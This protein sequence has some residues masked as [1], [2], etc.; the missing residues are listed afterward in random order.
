LLRSAP[1]LAEDAADP[2]VEV[3]LKQEGGVFRY[4]YTNLKRQASAEWKDVPDKL[5]SQKELGR[6]IREI[7]LRIMAG[8]EINSLPVPTDQRLSV[9]VRPVILDGGP[10]GYTVR[11][12]LDS[13]EGGYTLPRGSVIGF[14]VESLAKAPLFYCLLNIES[15]GL[16]NAV[17]PAKGLSSRLD[18]GMKYL[19]G[20][21]DRSARLVT[22][23]GLDSYRLYVSNDPDRN[24]N[25]HLSQLID[26]EKENVQAV[27][28]SLDMKPASGTKGPGLIE[29]SATIMIRMAAE[30]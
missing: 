17:Y 6:R 22:D 24:M 20:L 21:N 4:R 23:P 18:P 5:R 11:Q 3:E 7:L 15:T 16:A 10:G 29:S 9:S 8:E 14:Q 1:F 19:I 28:R 25:D 26:R 12:V 2:L 13:V 27:L 30:K